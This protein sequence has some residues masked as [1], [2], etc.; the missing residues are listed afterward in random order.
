[1]FKNLVPV[2]KNGRAPSIPKSVMDKT[3]GGDDRWKS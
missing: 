2:T 3:D 1:M